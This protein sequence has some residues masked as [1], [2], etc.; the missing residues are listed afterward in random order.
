[1]LGSLKGEPRASE[2]GVLWWGVPGALF[3][4]RACIYAPARAGGVWLRLRR[5]VSMGPGKTDG[6]RGGLLMEGGIILTGKN[7][8]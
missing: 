6:G 8:K 2:G 1:M 5:V 7:Q 4:A 3:F